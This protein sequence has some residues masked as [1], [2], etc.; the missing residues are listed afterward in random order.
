L[1][2]EYTN[3]GWMDTEKAARLVGPGLDLEAGKVSS[4]DEGRG[5]YYYFYEVLEGPKMNL[6]R[7]AFRKARS[8]LRE[9]A[10]ASGLARL[11]AVPIEVK[12]WAREVIGEI[13][14]A[15]R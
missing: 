8:E 4:I 1:S 11:D 14:R 6:N 2:L 13:A 15:P 3:L 12:P 7:D 5:G 10:K 9:R